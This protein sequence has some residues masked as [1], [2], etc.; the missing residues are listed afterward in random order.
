MTR[1]IVGEVG[2]FEVTGSGGPGNDTLTGGG[3]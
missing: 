3:S 1:S 2:A